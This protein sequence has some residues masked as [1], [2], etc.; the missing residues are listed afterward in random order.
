MHLAHC[1]R[2]WVGYSWDLGQGNHVQLCRVCTA[3]AQRVSVI[4][5]SIWM[6]PPDYVSPA[7]SRF[8]Y[9]G[10]SILYDSPINPRV[11]TESVAKATPCTSPLWTA[12]VL[13][14]FA[15]FIQTQVVAPHPFLC[16]ASTP[17]RSACTGRVIS[18]SPCHHCL[19]ELSRP[20]H[21]TPN[22]VNI[23]PN[24]CYK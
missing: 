7:P 1:Q 17:G 15:A 24:K 5:N 4:S 10:D 16:S 3:Q 6:L 18:A 11:Q 23:C 2:F 22:N 19:Q 13:S 20:A 21:Q 8:L 9:K 12:D 14:I